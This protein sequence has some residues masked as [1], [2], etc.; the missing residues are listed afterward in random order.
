[1][2]DP[3][4]RIQGRGGSARCGEARIRRGNRNQGAGRV[5]LTR[6]DRAAGQ[7]SNYR[8]GVRRQLL[9]QGDTKQHVFNGV[10][11]EVGLQAGISRSGSCRLV[12]RGGRPNAYLKGTD[13]TLGSTYRSPPINSRHREQLREILAFLFF[14]ELK[15]NLETQPSYLRVHQSFGILR[16][17]R[18]AGHRWLCQISN[19]QLSDRSALILAVV[20]FPRVIPRSISPTHR[21]ARPTPTAR[22]PGASSMVRVA[23]DFHF[24]AGKV[25]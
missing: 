11:P 13:R 18:L 21:P 20:S 12:C 24:G 16:F 17:A 1:M 22:F 2:V 3:E 10:A 19:L 7:E 5:H 6:T 23:V 25:H 4:G 8:V 14:N 15:L 9:T